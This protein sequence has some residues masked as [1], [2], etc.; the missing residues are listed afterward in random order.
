VT[1]LKIVVGAALVLVAGCGSSPP[2]PRGQVP[3]APSAAPSRAP[4]L[5]LD[6]EAPERPGAAVPGAPQVTIKLV[7]DTAKKAHIFW[8]RKDLG[9]APL[10]ILRPRGSGPL[11]LLVSAPGFLPLHTRVFTDRDDVLSLRLYDAESAR[12]LLG[13]P[14]SIEGP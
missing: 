13:Y 1:R 9:V 8:G 12:G 5:P 3:E 10:E 4:D 6:D 11:D 7:A 14:V 2:A